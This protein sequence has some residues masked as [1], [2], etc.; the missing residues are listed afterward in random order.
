[1]LSTAPKWEVYRFLPGGR[2]IRLANSI[3]SLNSYKQSVPLSFE[4]ML[5]V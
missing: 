3:A 2:L 1:M 5:R 4:V